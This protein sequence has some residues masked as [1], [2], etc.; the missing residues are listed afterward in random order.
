VSA[1]R[2]ATSRKAREVAHPLILTRSR[3]TTSAL[4]YAN[5]KEKAEVVP[6]SAVR[7]CVNANAV[8]EQMANQR[9]KDRESVPDAHEESGRVVRFGYWLVCT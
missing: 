2:Q 1:V 9:E 3:G 8:V 6:S 5:T 4:E 7:E